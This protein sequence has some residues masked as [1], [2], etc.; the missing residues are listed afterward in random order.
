MIK[1]VTEIKIHEFS[2]KFFL[3]NLV[4]EKWRVIE[5]DLHYIFS[6]EK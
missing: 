6:Q 3:K 2:L 5:K 1:R 4:F